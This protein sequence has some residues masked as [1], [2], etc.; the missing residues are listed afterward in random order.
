MALADLHV[1]SIHS[2]HPSEWFL[3]RIGA[4][5][6]YTDP[7]FIYKKAKENGMNF[8]TITDHNRITGALML[9]LKYPNEVFT[10]VESTVYFPEDNAKVHILVYGLSERQFNE[11]Q[12]IRKDIYQFRAFI[13]QENLAYSVAHPT[14]SVNNKLN[15]T[16]LERLA[17]MFDVFE[18]I[19]G[20]R[21]IKNNNIWVNAMGNLNSDKI[22]DIYNKYRIEPISEDPWVKNFTGGSD[23]HAGFFIGKT[24]TFTEAET[25]EQFLNQIKKKKTIAGGRSNDYKSLAFTIY[26]I[27]ID[28]SKQKS[29]GITNPIVKQ[30]TEN[31]FKDYTLKTQT[32][33]FN[34][35]S[36]L[37]IYNILAK[38]KAKKDPLNEKF[39][40][41]MSNI[42]DKINQNTDDYFSNI[43]LKL[44]DLADELI[45]DLVK[46]ANNNISNGEFLN[47]FKDMFFLFP[48]IF[49]SLPF[50]STLKHINKGK[51]LHKEITESFDLCDDEKKKVLWFT[52]T[53]NDLNGVS[54]TLQ[55]ISKKA[56][57]MNY[58]LKIVTCSDS[59]S[60]EIIKE[61]GVINLDKIYS[62]NLPHYET[63]SI[64]LPSI[65]KSI[66]FLT[67]LNPSE[68]YIS[69][70]GP[71]GLVGLLL[72]KLLNIPVKGVYHTDFTCQYNY[73]DEDSTGIELLEIYTKWFYSMLDEI[74]VPTIAYKK[75]LADRAYDEKK[76][77]VFRRGI[78]KEIFYYQKD[79]TEYFKQKYSLPQGIN[80]LYSG[81]I[82]KDKNLDFLI[83]LFCR[84]VNDSTLFNYNINLIIA[85]DGPYL[86]EF[87][88]K[89][90]K[91][92]LSQKEKVI[93][94]GKVNRNDLAEL[95]SVAD[96]FL[97]PS[98][99]DTFGMVVLE[100]LACGLPC[101]VSD[102]GGPA[103][104]IT[105]DISG[106]ICSTQSEDK[107][108]FA[109]KKFINLKQ[110]NNN[111][112]ERLRTKISNLTHSNYD[113]SVILN[114]IMQ[115]T[116][117]DIS[118]KNRKSY[119]HNIK[120][121]S[122]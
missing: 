94:L 44:S 119:K 19:N 75:I 90:K 13:I 76:M 39:Y 109:I 71:V 34:I 72:G 56:K 3:Q 121:P 43:Y 8:I 42:N 98:N 54:F 5:E 66:D 63:Y 81:R 51:P 101:I 58:D 26:K 7:E 38:K 114:S 91:L 41:L 29:G 78:E 102:I 1:H 6:S 96:L 100:A 17:L 61:T 120:I 115:T 20:G 82:S 37:S 55:T 97:F 50:F 12:K 104:L 53:F 28:F 108:L 99:T 65:L 83:Y 52:D 95:Y 64:S 74:K 112:F 92:N 80:L 22:N 110:N 45:I 23:D 24:Y 87:K 118:K 117:A 59:L 79:K 40:N 2:E 60:K 47:L 35:F 106:D 11:I 122:W 93:I 105:K 32:K 67:N 107:W 73:I 18:G 21:D 116:T 36:K 85:G 48:G 4:A 57:K 69:T 16:H 15:I 77:T 88:T 70:P 30:I 103:D 84:L 10:G 49:L 46:K 33:N 89:I 86:D 14:Y 68:I 31:L 25:P 9:K 111:E 113:W 27:A 62:F